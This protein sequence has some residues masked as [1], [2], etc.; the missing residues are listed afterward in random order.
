MQTTFP[1]Q[2]IPPENIVAVAK[3]VSSFPFC[4]F[5][6]MKVESFVGL[7]KSCKWVNAVITQ[8]RS[9]FIPYDFEVII[10][11]NKVGHGF[12]I[13]HVKIIGLS[14]QRCILNYFHISITKTQCPDLLNKKRVTSPNTQHSAI[15]TIKTTE[16]HVIQIIR[17]G[18]YK[19]FNTIQ[20]TINVI[21]GI[22]QKE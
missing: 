18:F 7:M 4:S 8:N 13:H 15:L 6:Q 10:D 12:F 1:I 20:S 2:L 9:T 14:R 11:Y 17:A 21:Y 19:S 16:T 3:K 5:F 22:D